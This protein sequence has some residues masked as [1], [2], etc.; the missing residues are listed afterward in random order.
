M[1]W[2][3]LAASIALAGLAVWCVVDLFAARSIGPLGP[4]VDDLRG[5]SQRATGVGIVAVL[6]G[7]LAL[8]RMKRRRFFRWVPG[9]VG[10]GLAVV[11]GATALVLG[12]LAALSLRTS[13]WSFTSM[14]ERPRLD[15]PIQIERILDATVVV[16]APD[17]SGD[18][19]KLAIGS[20]AII[21]TDEHRAWIVTNSHVAMPYADVAAF[22]DARK[23][24]PVWVQLSDG[25]GGRAAVRWTAKPPLDI[26]LVELPIEDAP[27]PVR[28]NIAGSELPVGASVVFVPNPYRSGWKVH[29]GQLLRRAT[30]HTPAGDYDLLHTDL[31]V[32]PG[33]SGSGLFDAHGELVGLNTWAH[34]ISLP[35]TAMRELLD[36]I[37]STTRE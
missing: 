14:P 13:D 24:Q 5:A 28:I 23:A 8:R 20:G 29:H 7:A 12:A 31:P 19:K 1:V 37:Q 3:A 10:H 30:H 15:V 34:G 16:L 22:R 27:A 6:F 33:D 17:A 36:V 26:A 18:G 11:S 21:A 4:L 9:L 35:A 2:L 32:I 25:R